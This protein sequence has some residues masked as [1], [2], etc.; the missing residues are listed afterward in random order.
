MTKYVCPLCNGLSD[1]PSN[2]CP[3]CGAG[4]SCDQPT[5]HPAELMPEFFDSND[6]KCCGCGATI[7]QTANPCPNCGRKDAG[8]EA[9]FLLQR[10]HE[11]NFFQRPQIPVYND[12]RTYL[13]WL[14][15][16][17]F[18]VSLVSFF[19]WGFLRMLPIPEY[20][21]LVLVLGGILVGGGCKVFHNY[22]PH[23]SCPACGAK[24]RDSTWDV[25]KAAPWSLEYI[26]SRWCENCS[27]PF[28]YEPLYHVYRD[29]LGSAQLEA[30]RVLNAA[31]LARFEQEQ[32]ETLLNQLGEEEPPEE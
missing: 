31:H 22:F 28:Y 12:L 3:H 20:G 13:D 23:G 27:Q 17:A 32:T 26:N 18:A 29:R 15:I 9:A 21:Y 11:A 1:Y 10:R 24:I 19:D 7:D 25:Q 14:G 16:G 2:F 5:F 4:L 30:T 6:P 8:P